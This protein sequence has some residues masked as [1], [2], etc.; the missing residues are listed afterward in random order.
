MPSFDY[1]DGMCR[2]DK[3]DCRNWDSSFAKNMCCDSTGDWFLI[4]VF[5]A[6]G[7]FFSLLSCIVAF[8]ASC[9]RLEAE[10]ARTVCAASMFLSF[11]TVAVAVAFYY[12]SESVDPAS[13]DL[14]AES[15]L[16]LK[17]NVNL[18]GNGTTMALGSFLLNFVFM[19]VMLYPGGCGMCNEC[20][21]DEGGSFK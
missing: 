5:I 11:A 21:S 6:A 14:Y 1:I 19:W 8:I 13:W 10:K 4:M 17:T 3:S 15:C 7:A 12:M 20:V 2:K 18:L 16:S 9:G